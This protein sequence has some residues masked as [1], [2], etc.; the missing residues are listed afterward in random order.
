MI[1]FNER[2]FQL[3][4]IRR[5]SKLFNLQT[6][7][8]YRVYGLKNAG[9]P[10]IHLSYNYDTVDD[11]FNDHLQTLVGFF[12][13]NNIDFVYEAGGG[14]PKVCIGLRK[15]LR[16]HTVFCC[17]IIQT[18]VYCLEGRLVLRGDHKIA[19]IPRFTTTRER[20]D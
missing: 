20:R 19:G 2:D 8:P 3:K 11:E 10:L 16:E 1:E 6:G 7:Q 13:R 18:I 14:T 17:C 9:N 5:E 4:A 15:D 12:E